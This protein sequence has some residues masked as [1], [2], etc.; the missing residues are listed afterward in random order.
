MQEPLK[1]KCNGYIIEIIQRGNKQ[2]IK[3][4]GESKNEYLVNDLKVEG[5][6]F[7]KVVE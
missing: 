7:R 4:Y 1:L 2:L 3:Y 5:K 6:F